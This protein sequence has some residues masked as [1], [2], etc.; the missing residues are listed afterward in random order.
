VRRSSSVTVGLAV[1]FV[2][3]GGTA[4]WCAVQADVGATI[5]AGIGGAYSAVVSEPLTIWY[6]P[7]LTALA[8][9]RGGFSL[10]YRHLFAL[11]DLEEISAAGIRQVR[12]PLTVGIGATHLGEPSIYTE[13]VGLTTIAACPLPGLSFG[14]GTRYRRTEFG[15][16]AAAYAGATIDLGAAW[17][18][19]TCWVAA[20]AVREITIDELY[21]AGDPGTVFDVS[22]AWS[23]PPDLTVAGRWSKE[24]DREGRFGVGQLLHINRRAT[25]LSGLRFDPIRY[26]VGGRLSHR[27]LRIDY[28]YESHPDLGGTHAVGMGWSW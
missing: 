12:R 14:V 22:L 21:G 25:F 5:L 19:D 16:G 4:N 24:S 10:S 28:C 27:S 20:A 26:A 8:D 11:S 15:G 23:L 2:I 1:A 6:N 9:G 7:A 17:R 13:F 18:P 3:S